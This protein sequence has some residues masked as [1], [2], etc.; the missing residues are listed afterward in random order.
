M[1]NRRA[2]IINAVLHLVIQ[3]GF[4][5]VSMRSVAQEAGLS[6]GMVQRHF[7]NKEEM[8]HQAMQH[9]V[10]Q[11]QQRFSAK[12]ALDS[13]PRETLFLLLGELFSVTPET[14]AEV[15][16]WLSSLHQAIGQNTYLPYLVGYYSSLLEVIVQLLPKPHNTKTNA[17]ALLALADGLTIQRLLGTISH[18]DALNVLTNQMTLLL[19]DAKPT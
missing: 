1:E 10:R 14:R 5:A 9:S 12:L 13:T 2:E 7:T 16:V 18:E 8:L 19:G 4:E 17:H 3:G 15:Q 6:L 11:F